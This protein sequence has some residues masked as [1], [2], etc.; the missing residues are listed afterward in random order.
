M[1]VLKRSDV[2]KFRLGHQKYLLLNENLPNEQLME[3]KVVS[4]GLPISVIVRIRN[5]FKDETISGDVKVEA[6]SR[7]LSLIPPN[8]RPG[9]VGFATSLMPQGTERIVHF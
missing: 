9:F 6:N 5:Q 1:V 2:L 8:R 3:E 7:K 4:K